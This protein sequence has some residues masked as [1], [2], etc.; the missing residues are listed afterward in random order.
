MF[1]PMYFSF[2]INKF[3]QRFDGTVAKTVKKIVQKESDI[4]FQERLYELFDKFNRVVGVFDNILNKDET[5]FQEYEDES[6]DRYLN[7]LLNALNKLYISSGKGNFYEIFSKHYWNETQDFILE[8]W[9]ESP[10]KI[11]EEEKEASFMKIFEDLYSNTLKKMPELCV[12]QLSQFK[13]LYRASTYEVYNSYNYIMPDP[14]YCKD[15]RWNDDGV[16]YLYLSYDDGDEDYKNIKLGQKTCFDELRLKD[17]IEVAICKFEVVRGDARILDLSYQNTDYQCVLNDM[18]SP[19]DDMEAEILNKI[20][21]SPKISAKLQRYAKNGRRDLFNKE[22][23]KIQKSLGLDELLQKTVQTHL[24][25]M[26]LGNICDAIFYGVDKVNDPQLEAYIPFRK[27]SKYLKSIGID[28]VAYRSTRMK[29]KGLSGT[30]LT[31]FDKNDAAFIPNSMEVY[32][33]DNDNY[34]LLKKY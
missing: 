20:K 14:I 4:S 33:Q 17:N 23:K 11:S 1:Y 3:I 31:L 16:A 25:Y 15:N 26:M 34:Q 8:L 18:S 22:I 9:K 5:V 7:K 24:T 19:L 21:N 29:L 6:H 12:K 28:G 13:N 30:C 10:D 2:E 27:F 32:V